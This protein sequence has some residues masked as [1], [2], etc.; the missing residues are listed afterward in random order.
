MARGQHLGKQFVVACTES[1][2][3]VSVQEMKHS[4]GHGESWE[5]TESS[6]TVDSQYT[7]GRECTADE[8]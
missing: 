1:I 7:R 5:S 3:Q 4:R 8:E 2:L 6:F